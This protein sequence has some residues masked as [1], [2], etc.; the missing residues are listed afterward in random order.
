MEF[1]PEI[2]DDYVN[3]R[4][5]EEVTGSTINRDVG[6]LKRIMNLAADP[7]QWNL[8]A[9][10]PI[11]GVKPQQEND[12][13][14]RELK[15][16]PAPNEKESEED[17]LF[18]ALSDTFTKEGKLWHDRRRLRLSVRI[19]LATGM[20]KEPVMQLQWPQF[21]FAQDVM[22]I[23]SK[24]K[25][26]TIPLPK[27]LRAELLDYKEWQKEKGITRLY[28]FPGRYSD[29]KSVKDFHIAWGKALKRAKIEDLRWHDLRRTFACRFYRK[30]RDWAALRDIL[31]HSDIKI[32]MRHY[33]HL[34]K[35][36]LTAAMN[37]YHEE[38]E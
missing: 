32:T 38:E 21:D 37:R 14:R 15:N 24:G 4:I 28:L 22:H 23:N 25:Q 11:A 18:K 5:E 17:R 2:I 3:R 12:A 34:L 31:G 30:T 6:S 35:E 8:I 16:V 36:D 19:T 7:Q 9:Y 33:A 20:R 29:K 13:R 26:L 1:T 27:K 10:N